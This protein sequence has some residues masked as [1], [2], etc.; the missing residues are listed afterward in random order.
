M[1]TQADTAGSFLAARMHRAADM[2]EN[3]RHRI[4][5]NQ[6][7][8][9]ANPLAH[10]L[11]TAP[12]LDAQMQGAID[13][14]FVPVST[15]GTLAGVARYFRAHHPHT[16]IVAVDVLGST[17]LGGA[18]APR[19]LTGIGASQVSNF[20]KPW[21]LDEVAYVTDA[22]AFAFCRAFAADTGISLGGSSGAVLSACCR[23][24]ARHLEVERPVCL[25]PDGGDR[26]A[27]SIYNDAWVGPSDIDAAPGLLDPTGAGRA[28]RFELTGDIRSGP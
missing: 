21:H 7:A 15:G 24:L 19:R 5:L 27:D 11:T 8:N 12:E 9:E 2:C 13:C 3:S 16:R 4:W 25:A 28:V 20:I 26:Y 1:V 17:A 10:Y 22:E 18:D 23:D 6:Y 14:L